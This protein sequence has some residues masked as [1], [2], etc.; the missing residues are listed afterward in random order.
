MNLAVTVDT[1]ET[2]WDPFKEQSD[3][4]FKGWT[5]FTHSFTNCFTNRYYKVI[6]EAICLKLTVVRGKKYVSGNIERFH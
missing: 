4:E 5:F 1:E 3:T 6:V 2:H